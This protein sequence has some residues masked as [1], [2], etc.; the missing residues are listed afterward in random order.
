MSLSVSPTTLPS[1]SPHEEKVLVVPAS[2][3]RELG[4]FRGFVAGDPERWLHR[5]LETGEAR[6]LSRALAE[7]DPTHL[8]LIPYVILKHDGLV[9]RYTRGGGAGEAR[10][11]TRGSIGV[12]G[13]V[14]ESDALPNAREGEITPR[15]AFERAI[16]RELAEEVAL[17]LPAAA[18]VCV[19]FLFD[20]STPVGRVHLGIVHMVELATPQARA[21]E[22]HLTDARLVPL[23]QLQHEWSTLETWSQLCAHHLFGIRPGE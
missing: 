15:V 17:D 23:A 11:R 6:F 10:L 7:E 1:R 16:W 5:L 21:R 13:H 2:L 14:D 18:P 4:A 9:F 19:G 12:G 22:E 8:Q 3:W 20:D